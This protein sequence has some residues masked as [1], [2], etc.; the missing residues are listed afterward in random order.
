M[1]KNIYNDTVTTERLTKFAYA[2]NTSLDNTVHPPPLI[3]RIHS[4][5]IGEWSDDGAEHEGR[6]ETS[7]EE[8]LDLSESI[9]G[10]DT[11]V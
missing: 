11:V 5:L 9:L 8:Q 4:Q 6:T 1:E 10:G 3:Y 7:D 2:I